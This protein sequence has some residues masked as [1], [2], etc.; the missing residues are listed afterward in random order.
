[1]EKSELRDAY[2]RG[3]IADELNEVYAEVDSTFTEMSKEYIV[4]V[5]YTHLIKPLVDDGRY[6]IC[7]LGS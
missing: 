1:M 2:V 5:S 4:A 7:F 6:T 3:V